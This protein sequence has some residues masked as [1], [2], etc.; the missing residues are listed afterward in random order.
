MCQ[1]VYG[2]MCTL[3]LVSNPF[4]HDIVYGHCGQLSYSIDEVSG[5]VVRLFLVRLSYS[6]Y[7]EEVLLSAYGRY[8]GKRVGYLG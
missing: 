4:M 6:N 3:Y 5:K 7:M 8:L 1:Y 2:P